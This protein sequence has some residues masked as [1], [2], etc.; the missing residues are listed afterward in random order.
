MQLKDRNDSLFLNEKTVGWKLMTLNLQRNTNMYSTSGKPRLT[1]LKTSV[2][3]RL[4]A[5]DFNCGERQDAVGF[6]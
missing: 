5:V 2:S 4:F 6:E 3:P 1:A